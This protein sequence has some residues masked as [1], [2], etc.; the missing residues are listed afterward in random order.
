MTAVT[1]PEGTD[2]FTRVPNVNRIGRVEISGTRPI[3]YLQTIDG[4]NR[5]SV[6]TNTVS[7]EAM[8]FAYDGARALEDNALIALQGVEPPLYGIGAEPGTAAAGEQVVLWAT[9]RGEGHPDGGSPT[10]EVR[11]YPPRRR[12]VGTDRH[13]PGH[14][15]LDVGST[16]ACDRR[17]A[18]GGRD[19]K[20]RGRRP[21][22]PRGARSGRVLHP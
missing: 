6:V 16:L 7:G 10:V 11:V 21:G 2:H 17:L 15:T 9:V 12:N 14:N 20:I 19:P 3:T 4:E 1:R 13:D 18:L 8:H 5:L 22:R